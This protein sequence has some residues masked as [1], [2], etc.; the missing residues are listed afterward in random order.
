MFAVAMR[1]V[2]HLHHTH[3]VEAPSAATPTMAKYV[4]FAFSLVAMMASVA[5]MRTTVI[6]VPS[7]QAA[8]AARGEVPSLHHCLQIARVATKGNPIT[9]ELAAGEHVVE[10]E[11]AMLDGKMSP[12]LAIKGAPGSVLTSIRTVNATIWRQDA[13]GAWS[14]V[15]DVPFA[16]DVQQMFVRN[17]SAVGGWSTL[18][19]ARWP[20]A[21]LQTVMDPLVSWAPTGPGSRNGRVVAPSLGATGIDFS[22]ALATLNVAHQFYTWTR[23]VANFTAFS[24]GS[25]AFDYPQNL[26]G[27]TFYANVTEPWEHNQ[28]FLSGVRGALDSEGEWFY[29]A[30]SATLSVMLPGGAKPAEGVLGVRTAQYCIDTNVTE[31]AVGVSGVTLSQLQLVGCTVRVDCTAQCRLESMWI[32]Y[33]TYNKLIP[34]SY[35]STSPYYGHASSTLLRGPNNS[36]VYNISVRYSVNRGMVLS[37]DGLNASEVLVDSA[38]WYGTLWY[39]CLA[40]S[41]PG[42]AVLSRATVRY[43]GNA[44]LTTSSPPVK[45]TLSNIHHGGQIGL[46]SANLY[47]GGV[48]DALTHWEQNWVWM[49]REKC[50]RGDDQSRNMTVVQNVMWDCGTPVSDKNDAGF[51]VVL[52]GNYHMLGRMTTFN[53]SIVDMAIPGCPEKYKPWVHQAPLLPHQNNETLVFN[54]AYMTL[55]G[56]AG[57]N[58]TDSKQPGGV[59]K[60]DVHASGIEAML[61]DAANHNFT[62]RAGSPL[63]DAGVV[64]PPFTDGYHGSAPDAG[65]YERGAPY[66]VPGCTTNPACADG[67]P[68]MIRRGVAAGG[69]L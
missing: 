37:G 7:N 13:D 67:E 39:P 38:S 45:V 26:P 41:G 43:C 63:V 12:G 57:C 31:P 51:G 14:T 16:E 35:P 1:L 49:A 6:V 40:F 23:Y 22:G 30:S 56:Q 48:G 32:E 24:N 42:G 21:N 52:K 2:Q 55:D 64:V 69:W 44:G 17:Q 60:G 33:P 36:S 11:A 5:S 54:S 19:E 53:T 20:N 4:V 15:L 50:L 46:D 29:N 3:S 27:I 59:Y 34:E 61:E 65:A 18:F 47:T 8:D 68:D 9:C 10:K 58:K 25:A 66:W 62:P 28:F